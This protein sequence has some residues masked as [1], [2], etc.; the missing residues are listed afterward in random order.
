MAGT[1]KGVLC[2]VQE[3]GTVIRGLGISKPGNIKQ[4]LRKRNRE[5]KD[6]KKEL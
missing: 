5:K 3:K 2:R 4:V 1:I 6:K